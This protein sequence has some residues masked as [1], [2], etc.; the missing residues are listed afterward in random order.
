MLVGARGLYTAHEWLHEIAHLM[1]ATVAIIFTNPS[2]IGTIWTAKNIKA[3][4]I[5]GHWAQQLIPFIPAKR[6]YVDLPFAKKENGWLKNKFIGL[7]GLAGTIGLVGLAWSL[8]GM[9]PLLGFI[10]LTALAVVIGG[11]QSG[12]LMGSPDSDAGRFGCG[13]YVLV[14]IV[15]PKG[16]SKKS[17]KPL[18]TWFKG[19]VKTLTVRGGQQA[20]IATNLA[21]KQLMVKQTKQLRNWAFWQEWDKGPVFYRNMIDD[22]FTRFENALPSNLVPIY[23]YSKY[24]VIKFLNHVRFS[25]GGLMVPEAAQPFQS[26]YERREVWVYDAVQ[27]KWKKVVRYVQITSAFNGDHD[28]S[29]IGIPYRAHLKER[30][31]SFANMRSFY[32]AAVHKYYPGMVTKAY[33]KR[34][35]RDG[36]H[37][38]GYAIPTDHGA[39]LHLLHRKGYINYWGYVN[40][41]FKGLDKDFKDSLPLN[42]QKAWNIEDI[43]GDI[44]SAL[45]GMPPGDGPILPLEQHLDLTQGNWFASLRYAHVMANHRNLEEARDD[46]LFEQARPCDRQCF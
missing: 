28:G 19:S 38:R 2:K 5:L 40:H 13:I 16:V 29:K 45:F 25:T 14:K 1:G 43:L 33:L 8:M 6:S 20:G 3:N 39:I 12:D 30:Q 27:Q 41:Q 32:S 23:N 34:M 36:E 17:I 21:D 15:D 44:E 37:E 4:K 7:S 24:G 42:M 11:L 31:L 18:L 10:A 46:I 35:V 22:L 26:P 9:T